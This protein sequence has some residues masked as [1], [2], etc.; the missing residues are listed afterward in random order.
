MADIIL[1]QNE[2]GKILVD[3][4]QEIYSFMGAKNAMATVAATVDKSK[5]VERRLTRS[6]RFGYEI[7]DVANTLPRLKGETTCLIGSRWDLPDP[8]RGPPGQIKKRFR[9]FTVFQGRRMLMEWR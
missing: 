7:A 3:P 9:L 5:I 6:F 1:S 4:H 8:V 2:C